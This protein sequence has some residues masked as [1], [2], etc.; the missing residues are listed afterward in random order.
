[1]R[2]K[3]RNVENVGKNEKQNSLREW[4]R[5]SKEKTE[6]KEEIACK[7]DEKAHIKVKM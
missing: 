6:M 1:M 3:T 5:R 7:K 4:R 2:K